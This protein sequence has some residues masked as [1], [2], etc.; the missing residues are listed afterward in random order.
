[1]NKTEY[2]QLMRMRDKMRTSA[3]YCEAAESALA[4]YLG[5]HSQ[6]GLARLRILTNAND[7]VRQAR[8]ALGG[9]TADGDED[10]FLQ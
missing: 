3:I 7:A 6:R 10:S 5:R 2:R 4:F 9:S 8:K 1:M